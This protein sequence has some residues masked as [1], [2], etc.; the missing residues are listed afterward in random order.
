[1]NHDGDAETAERGGVRAVGRSA[2]SNPCSILESFSADEL[3]M[4]KRHFSPRLRTAAEGVGCGVILA[5]T[6]VSAGDAPWG[7]RTASRSTGSRGAPISVVTPPPGKE[8]WANSPSSLSL[9][10]TPGNRIS[11]VTPLASASTKVTVGVS[12]STQG[13]SCSQSARA[14]PAL[15][16]SA[17]SRAT[18]NRT[19]LI[20]PSILPRSSIARSPDPPASRK[21]QSISDNFFTNES[22]S[23][24]AGWR[25]AWFPRPR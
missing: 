5:A 3:T 15:P 12:P 7:R 14:G 16:I 22:P 18:R 13:S 19:I 2:W 9:N 23:R 4:R 21:G 6:L 11:T 8:K 17:V 1:M 10:S 24:N 25:L 20:E